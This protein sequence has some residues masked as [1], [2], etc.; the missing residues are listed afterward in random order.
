MELTLPQEMETNSSSFVEFTLTMKIEILLAL[1]RFRMDGSVM[2]SWHSVL[3]RYQVWE[4]LLYCIG[5]KKCT[6][7]CFRRLDLFYHMLLSITWMIMIT[8]IL[9][10]SLH[11]GVLPNPYILVYL[12]H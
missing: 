3:Q 11:I 7:T 2:A 6:I 8:F 5:V 9:P 10:V 4:W 1:V 12:S